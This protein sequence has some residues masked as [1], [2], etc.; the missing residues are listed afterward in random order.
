MSNARHSL[1][2]TPSPTLAAPSRAPSPSSSTPSSPDWPTPNCIGPATT[3]LDLIELA[4][5]LSSRPSTLPRSSPVS[6]SSCASPCAPPLSSHARSSPRTIPSAGFDTTSESFGREIEARWEGVDS[7]E[8]DRSDSTHT[9]GSVSGFGQN[10]E[11]LGDDDDHMFDLAMAGPRIPRSAI[12]DFLDE[13]VAQHG[14]DMSIVDKVDEEAAE[15]DKGRMEKDEDRELDQAAPTESE[16]EG[17]SEST[18]ERQGGRHVVEERD[19]RSASM[20]AAATGAGSSIQLANLALRPAHAELIDP[21]TLTDIEN[22]KDVVTM[23]NKTRRSSRAK[24]TVVDPVRRQFTSRLDGAQTS[25]LV[26]STRTLTASRSGSPSPSS[27]NS[28]LVPTAS[29]DP[30][31]L[32]GARYDAAHLARLARPRPY[33]LPSLFMRSGLAEY[34]MTSLDTLLASAFRPLLRP[35][36]VALA[37]CLAQTWLDAWEP[38]VRHR[39]LGVQVLVNAPAWGVLLFAFVECLLLAVR[40][41]FVVAVAGLVVAFANGLG[42]NGATGV[43]Q[44]PF[45]DAGSTAV[46]NWNSTSSLRAWAGAWTLS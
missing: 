19:P 30:V 31:A 45:L 17:E 40:Y 24:V 12:F 28:N 1:Q 14:R 41:P 18:R 3:E 5:S 46:R 23:D 43:A 36:V 39:A 26:L 37:L 13:A 22:V 2:R 25:A 27:P 21:S 42:S 7:F 16:G 4:S 10:D 33:P 29:S 32:G 8:R 35:I 34:A 9:F 11:G 15:G 44:S 38:M 6:S 20:E